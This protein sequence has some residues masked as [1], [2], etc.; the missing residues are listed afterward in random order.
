VRT[1]G[2]F[3]VGAVHFC[4]EIARIAFE[5]RQFEAAVAICPGGLARS[6]LRPVVD[7]A[8]CSGSAVLEHNPPSNCY[9]AC[10]RRYSHVDIGQV[11]AAGES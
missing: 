3:I 11:F 5:D 8:T 9:A 1:R 4:P 10:Q 7:I 2:R 6:V